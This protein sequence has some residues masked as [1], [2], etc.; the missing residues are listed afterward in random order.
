[1]EGV[2][3]TSVTW[4]LAAFSG[5]LTLIPQAFIDKVTGNFD[6]CGDAA[7]NYEAL[8]ESDDANVQKTWSKLTR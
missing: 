7:Q 8:I 5:G 1:M 3:K 2:L 4:A 6:V